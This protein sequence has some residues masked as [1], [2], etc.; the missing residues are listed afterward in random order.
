VSGHG[1]GRAETKAPPGLARHFA[2]RPP[3][4]R[5]ETYPAM[6]MMGF[7]GVRSGILSLKDLRRRRPWIELRSQDLYGISAVGGVA[8]TGRWRSL[9]WDLK[10]LSNPCPCNTAALVLVSKSTWPIVD[11]E[12]CQTFLP[13]RASAFRPS[14]IRCGGAPSPSPPHIIFF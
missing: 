14:F 13:A 10:G 8:A 11:K 7:S 9:N 2:R 5:A 1:G 12:I 3:P 4:G 6:L